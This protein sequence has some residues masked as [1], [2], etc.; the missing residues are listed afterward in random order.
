M[1]TIWQFIASF[2][3]PA[4][5]GLLLLLNLPIPKYVVVVGQVLCRSSARLREGGH[6]FVAFFSLFLAKEL[7]RL[8]AE[9][10]M[11]GERCAYDS[12]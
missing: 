9:R 5:L 7:V 6:W 12:T 10:L 3:L 8:H 4:P 1:S 2:A 11:S